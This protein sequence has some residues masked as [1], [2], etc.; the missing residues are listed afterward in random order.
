MSTSFGWEG[1][2]AKPGMVRSVSGW[3]RGVQIKLWDSSRTRAIP[4]PPRGVFMKRQIHVYLYLYLVLR[5]TSI[6]GVWPV[7]YPACWRYAPK[8]RGSCV[9]LH[10]VDEQLSLF[11]YV[12]WLCT[13]MPVNMELRDGQ[14]I[15][16]VTNELVNVAPAS[17]SACCVFGIKFIDPAPC[18]STPHAPTFH[19]GYWA[20]CPRRT[21]SLG[22]DLA[23]F[24]PTRGSW[25]LGF[26][27]ETGRMQI[28]WN[29]AAFR[30]TLGKGKNHGLRENYEI[31]DKIMFNNAQKTVP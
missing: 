6:H 10:C 17:R 14:H 12:K 31:S 25:A 26:R 11:V 16:V 27:A 20:N 21:R 13:Y 18:T 19:F 29:F 15:G 28:F 4:E 24:Q 30:W 1:K 7:R 5:H 2:L 9:R 22:R 23:P 3:T 8:L